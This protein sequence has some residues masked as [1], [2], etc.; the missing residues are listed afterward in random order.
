[1]NAASALGRSTTARAGRGLIALLAAATCSISA[2]ALGQG[3]YVPEVGIF[4][5][6][7]VG[8]IE[9]TPFGILRDTRCPDIRLCTRDG[10]LIVSAILHDY[11]G[12]R[13]VM[14]ERDRP[15]A[16]PGGW[17]VLR[18]AATPPTLRGAIPVEDYRLDFEFVPLR[19]PFFPGE[20]Y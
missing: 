6:A 14:L 4:E 15:I 13:E 8:S 5:R 10:T 7:I 19:P 3:D 18:G 12:T 11:R 9:I 1:M 2:P 20:P 16:V 17:L